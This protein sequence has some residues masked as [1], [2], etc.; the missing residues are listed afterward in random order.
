MTTDSEC[1][2]F[3]DAVGVKHFLVHIVLNYFQVC[4]FTMS[5]KH[6]SRVI[7]IKQKL[8]ALRIVE[9]DAILRNV[10]VNYGFGTSTVSDWIR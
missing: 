1:I 10:S 5:T 9:N 2:H 7:T 4:A 8:G 6:K 3:C